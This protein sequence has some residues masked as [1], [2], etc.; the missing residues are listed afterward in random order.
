MIRIIFLIAGTM[1]FVASSAQAANYNVNA[2]VP[3][4]PP[5]VPSQI[6][7][8]SNGFTTTTN[9]V[10]VGGTCQMMSPA[11]IVSIWRNGASI[12][13]VPCSP[14]GTFFVII[15]LALGNNT[16]LPRSSSITGQ[17]GVDGAAVNVTYAVPPVVSEPTPVAPTSTNEQSASTPTPLNQEPVTSP[18]IS[19]QE[20]FYYFESGT[21]VVLKLVITEGQSPYTMT[22]DWGDGSVETKTI[23]QSGPVELRH[24]YARPATYTI[25]AQITDVKGVSTSITL[26]STSFS[27]DSKAASDETQRPEKRNTIAFAIGLLLTICGVLFFASHHH[28]VSK[29]K[30]TKRKKS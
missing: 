21:D 15:G 23:P 4:D 6:T 18:I 19:S 16:L 14:D 7:V 8:P 27:H 3:A 22:V 1:L 9:S 2:V 11:I 17:F 29:Q 26:T 12:G 28:T 10:G 24:R 13:S 25:R 5:T 30:G 20:P